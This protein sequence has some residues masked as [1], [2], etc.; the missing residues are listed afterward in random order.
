MTRMRDGEG[1][2]GPGRVERIELQGDESE[3]YRERE[4]TLPD[5]VSAKDIRLE[6][7]EALVRFDGRFAGEV[8]Y[9]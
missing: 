7:E 8:V 3:E 4:S 6:H 5:L 9:G 2:D 1:G